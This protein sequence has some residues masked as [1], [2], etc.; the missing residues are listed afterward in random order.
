MRPH[1][2]LLLPKPNIEVVRQRA[3]QPLQDEA[4]LRQRIIKLT[5]DECH[6]PD[7]FPQGCDWWAAYRFYLDVIMPAKAAATCLVYFQEFNTFKKLLRHLE[8]PL[9]YQRA[10]FELAELFWGG[11]SGL[12]EQTTAIGLANEITLALR[13]A[14]AP[15]QE[16]LDF[17]QR[18]AAAAGINWPVKKSFPLDCPSEVYGSTF[19]DHEAGRFSATAHVIAH[20]IYWEIANWE[21]K[22]SKAGKAD[23]SLPLNLSQRLLF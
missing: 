4:L 8:T 1:H 11:G 14:L 21:K 16:A 17:I 5:D 22:N 7:F 3:N 10:L 9:H 6:C 18:T 23:S 15:G 13:P 12:K 19:Y 2:S 20:G